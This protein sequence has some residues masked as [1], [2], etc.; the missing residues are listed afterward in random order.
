MIKRK[1]TKKRTSKPK[2]NPSNL[3][4][5]LW[6]T[7]VTEGTPIP[8]ELKYGKWYVVISYLGYNYLDDPYLRDEDEVVIQ[9][10]PELVKEL[11]EFKTET[12][13][14]EFIKKWWSKQ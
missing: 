3:Y 12:E 9:P 2:R 14:L 1:P 6:S 7:S 8:K 10:S 11:H 13:A 4:P 5:F